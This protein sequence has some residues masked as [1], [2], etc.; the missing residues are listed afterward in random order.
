MAKKKDYLA[1][2]RSIASW[3]KALDLKIRR[4]NSM[5]RRIKDDPRNYTRAGKL[6][7]SGRTYTGTG[8]ISYKLSP[9]AKLMKL[10]GEKGNA[11]ARR[12]GR[13]GFR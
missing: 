11:V 4:I 9:V 8:Q 2:G 6:R 3:R 7:K 1:R 12:R 13:K 5:M 10:G